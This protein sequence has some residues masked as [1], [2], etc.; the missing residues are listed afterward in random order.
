MGWTLKGSR[1]GEGLTSWVTTV[2]DCPG[3]LGEKAEGL[4]GETREHTHFLR[5]A[6]HACSETKSHGTPLSKSRDPS[7]GR[8]STSESSPQAATGRGENSWGFNLDGEHTALWFSLPL[9]ETQYFPSYKARALAP[10]R[11][12]GYFIT[13]HSRPI[14]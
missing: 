5:K 8:V 3:R 7:K 14:R 12:P 6:S 2:C 11:K 1:T 4:T 10:S 9:D 13:S